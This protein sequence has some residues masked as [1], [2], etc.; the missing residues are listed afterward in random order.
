MLQKSLMALALAGC[1]VLAGCGGGAGSDAD[2]GTPG[3]PPPAARNDVVGPLDVVQAPLSTQV[4][5]PLSAALAGTPLASVVGCVEETVINDVIDVVDALALGIQPGALGGSAVALPAAAAS[6]QA[7]VSDLVADLQGLVL[8]MAGGGAG[9]T[10]NAAPRAGLGNPLAG[11]PLAA[12]GNLLLPVLA[13]VQG[14]LDGTAGSPASALSLT[15]LTTVL[16]QLSDA[17]DTAFALVP[18]DA[19]AAPFVG[20]S[21]GLVQQSLADLQTSVGMAAVGNPT[22]VATAITSTVENLLT[23]L[24]V[25]LVPINLIEDTSGRSGAVSGPIQSAIAQVTSVLG[26]GVGTLP[27]VALVTSLTAAIG[28]LLNPLEGDVLPLILDPILAA[29]G[30]TSGGGLIP[31]GV[32]GTPL[33]GVLGIVTGILS[34]G[35]G[36]DPLT[37]LLGSLLG[38][39]GGFCPLAGTP[40][41]GLCGLLGG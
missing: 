27:G 5:A 7:E 39:V 17:F 6:V 23:G 22:A 36:G 15:Q 26:G 3:G 4:L 2:S 9:C 29:I 37:S 19:L 35:V 11:T 1:A 34:G 13:Q 30:G 10:S 25:D 8:S 41:A 32:T 31:G 24:L 38:G 16:G 28:P 33:D 21:L 12:F 18:A 20:P 14:T 40:L